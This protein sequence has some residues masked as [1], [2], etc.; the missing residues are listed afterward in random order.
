M[1]YPGGGDGQ[2]GWQYP[3]QPPQQPPQ[4]QQPQYPTQ[5]YPPQQ[6]PYPTQ[7]YPGQPPQFGDR[8]GQLGPQQ[9]VGY[10]YEQQPGQPYG[11]PL[12]P[13]TYWQPP[14]PPKRRTGLIAGIV[15]AVVVLAGGGVGTWFA[16]NRTAQAGAT[17]SATPQA[18]ATKLLDDLGHTDV[19]GLVDDLPP[20][21]AAFLRDTI[22]SSTET[23]KRLQIVKPDADPNQQTDTY[24]HTSGIRFDPNVQQINDHL[25]ITQLDAGTITVSGD[26]SK[27]G[28]TDKFLKAIAPSG[29]LPTQSQ[30]ITVPPD[31]P[32]RIATIKVNGQW[33]PSLFY[34][35]ADA[36][37]RSAHESWPRDSIPAIGSASPDDAVRGFVQALLDGDFSK[38][39]G[40]TAPDEMAALHDA[41]PAIVAAAGSTQPSGA[42]INALSLNDKD[43]PGGVEAVMSTM[44]MDVN[45]DQIHVSLSGGCLS[46]EGSA[47]GES[48]KTCASDIGTEMERG[49]GSVLPPAFGKLMQDISSGIMNGGIGIV[50]TQVGGQW[51]VSPAR[52]LTT[53]TLNIFG[54]INPDDFA[55]LLQYGSH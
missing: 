37:L 35:I 50:T 10:G 30:T 9:P 45:G 16:L 4:H 38:A 46:I 32:A 55:G 6:Q 22:S 24:I 39:I 44:T 28:Y 18:A 26:I 48:Q 11:H 34:S 23:L 54:S 29:Q 25:A 31:Q 47:P 20:A 8:F 15:V 5:P 17:G 52:T 43:V 1:T 7:P 42:K 27:F 2:G 33:Y 40:M 41:G 21:E 36:G 51:Y 49:A 19:L 3:Q 53:V 12:G 13:A 14:Q